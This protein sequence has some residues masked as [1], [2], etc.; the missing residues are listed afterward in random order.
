MV[1]KKKLYDLC[2]NYTFVDNKG[3]EKGIDFNFEA[4]Q[5]FKCDKWF[6]NT[7]NLCTYSETRWLVQIQK[8][9]LLYICIKSDVKCKFFILITNDYTIHS[10]N[11]L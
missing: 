5:T 3:R 8:S 10:F 11:L 2:V 7:I 9:Y 1:L 4:V 6:W